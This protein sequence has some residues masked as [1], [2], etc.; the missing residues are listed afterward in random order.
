MAK[1]F[2]KIGSGCSNKGRC[3]VQY[4]RFGKSTWRGGHEDIHVEEFFLHMGRAKYA[5]THF[6]G[7]S[8]GPSQFRGRK[9]I[10][11]TKIKKRTI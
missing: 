5:E 8:S 7:S 2:K 11:V 10:R 3:D 1:R 9:G 4:K 6:P